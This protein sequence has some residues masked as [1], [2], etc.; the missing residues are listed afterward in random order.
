MP[1]SVAAMMAS[2]T[3]EREGLRGCGRWDGAAG[4]VR[5]RFGVVIENEMYL[6]LLVLESCMWSGGPGAG[7][8]IDTSWWMWRGLWC[9]RRVIVLPIVLDGGV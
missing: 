7:T 6:L 2:G 8:C 3:G 1:C 9:V 5:S 4:E